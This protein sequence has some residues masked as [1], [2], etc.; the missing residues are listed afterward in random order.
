MTS[1][2]DLFVVC[3][4]CGS[5]VSPYITECPYCGHRLRRRAP[6][7]PPVN[8]PARTTLRGRARSLL[9]GSKPARARAR[10]R[11]GGPRDHPR[12][13]AAD[14]PYA[15]IALV[16]A[17][18]AVWVTE[19][20]EGS[21]YLH[22]AVLGPLHG[23]WWRLFTSEFAYVNGVYA[24]VAILTIAIFGWLLERRH[25]PAPVLAL[26]LGAGA[27]GALVASAVYSE[28][29]VSGG[30]GAALA[31]LAAWAAPDLGA[32]RAREYREGDLLGAGALAALLLALP[33]AR[34]EASWLAGVVG[35]LLGLAVGL[36]MHRL[37]EQGA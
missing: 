24:F 11:S 5:E 1:G 27:T 10:T 16:A 13:W 33:F 4:Q 3:K 20:A 7:L 9:T 25:G 19:H 23:D 26:F 32:A 31:L 2:A 30:N 6:K 21:L 17:S 34:P 29:L 37:S 12:R 22:T 35:G 8:A 18:C 15:T 14:R 28:P 36:G